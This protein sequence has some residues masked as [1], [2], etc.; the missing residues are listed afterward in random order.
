MHAPVKAAHQPMG[1][2][3]RARTAI[4]PLP[5][6]CCLMKVPVQSIAGCPDRVDCL[7]Q[8]AALSLKGMLWP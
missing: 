6:I 5:I 8:I 7:E 4:P 1:K 3:V 2:L